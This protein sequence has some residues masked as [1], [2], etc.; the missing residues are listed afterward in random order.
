SP[1]DPGGAWVS[2]IQPASR[3]GLAKCQAPIGGHEVPLPGRG[4]PGNRRDGVARGRTGAAA[5][6]C[7]ARGLT[8]DAS[9]RTMTTAVPLLDTPKAVACPGRAIVRTA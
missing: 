2:D 5:R 6:G 1:P 7:P 8:G 3:Q 9:G 4:R